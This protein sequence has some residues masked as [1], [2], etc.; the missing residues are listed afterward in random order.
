VTVTA[1][2][3]GNENYN[4]ASAVN[5]QFTVVKASQ[6]ITFN[7]LANK[8]YSDAPFSVSASSSSGL[9]VNFSV[10]GPATISGSSVTITGVGTVTVTA[11]QAGN[12]NYNAASAVNQQFT[13][14]KASQTITFN[15]LAN[16]TYGDA[17]FSVSASSSSGLAV[18]FLVAGPAT[19]SGSTVTITG[20]GPVTVTASQAGDE[21]YNAATAVNQQFTVAKASQT[22]TFNA[23]SNKTYGD[24]QFTI[25]ASASSG[26]EVGFLVTSGLATISNNTLTITGAGTVTVRASQSGNGNYLA[27][28]DVD[29]S[30]TVA[31]AAQTIT[32]DSLPN[33]T[34]GDA[35]FTISASASSGLGIGFSVGSGPATISGNTVTITAAGAVTVRASQGGDSNYLPAA[36][37]DRSLTVAKASQTITFDALSNKTYGDAP[38]TVN[39]F[40]SSGLGVSFSI[41]SG[42]ATI[43]GNTVTITG[44]G[45]VTV[46]ASQS[47]NGNYE[48]A[49][50]VDRSFTVSKA[51]PVITWN[52]PADIAQGTALSA[53]QLNAT[54]NVPGT[55][56]YAPSTGNVLVYV[57]SQLLSVTFI[58]TDS[59]NYDRA[60]ANV[61]INVIACPSGNNASFI[62]NPRT[63]GPGHSSTLWWNV[64]NA[65]SVSIN[66]VAGTFSNNAS[67]TVSPSMTSTYTLT[68]IGP[69]V[70][71]PLT[72]QTAVIVDACP[73][74][75]GISFAADPNPVQAG[76]TTSL[77]WVV[78]DNTTSV[79]VFEI[80]WSEEECEVN[81]LYSGNASGS[82]AIAP[83]ETTTYSL[84]VWGAEGCPA[85]TR[86]V[87]VNVLPNQCAADSYFYAEPTSMSIIREPNFISLNWSMAHATSVRITDEF[88]CDYGTFNPTGTIQ[89]EA[90]MTTAYTI[91]A[92]GGNSPCQQY[93]MRTGFNVT[94]R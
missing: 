47:G 79:G 25:S 91:T 27:A 50:N 32:F 86:D 80:M 1:S 13:V 34:Y 64:P 45:T 26:L 38:F 73:S 63:I 22:I 21:N 72:L 48:S 12:E 60:T 43:S 44:A 40:A 82:I 71:S 74:D 17:P 78:P 94:W 41:A 8:T 77:S 93:L 16:K 18:N 9:A 85:I 68:A 76:D 28:P 81:I 24:A 54:A 67:T 55:F 42:P 3:A 11:S 30:F 20:V 52:N 6:T 10:A 5:Q 88:G 51:T 2:Q 84:I 61:H 87:V 29:R 36:N 23:L 92:T 39:G 58:P 66:G 53:T 69:S 7:A 59:A 57:G 46:R 83:T 35:P 49:P 33:K 15:A 4:A 56:A 19:I 90:D 37:V 70:C 89:V 62:S 75:E 31:K 65:T 14:V